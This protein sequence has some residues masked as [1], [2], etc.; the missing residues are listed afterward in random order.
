MRS[1]TGSVQQG[2]KHVASSECCLLRIRCVVYLH[3]LSC[4]PCLSCRGDVGCYTTAVAGPSH[5]VSSPIEVRFSTSRSMGTRGFRFLFDCAGLANQSERKSERQNGREGDREGERTM[6]ACSEGER[7]GR[8]RAI[9]AGRT[10]I[11]NARKLGKYSLSRCIVLAF[12]P[13]Q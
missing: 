8:L 5:T 12:H 1:R 7:M 4:R 3:T 9:G 10:G 13:S 6:Q 2:Q 11:R